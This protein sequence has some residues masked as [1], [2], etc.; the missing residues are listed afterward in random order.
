MG[1]K[2]YP[3]TVLEECKCEIK[4][5]KTENFINDGFDSSSSDESN[6]ESD[7]K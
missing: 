6:S 2:H 4:K 5:K 1:K 3:R 7:N